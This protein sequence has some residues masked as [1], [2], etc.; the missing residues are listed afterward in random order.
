MI[1]TKPARQVLEV[2]PRPAKDPQ[3]RVGR[4]DERYKRIAPYYDLLDWPFEFFRY[5]RIRR[6]VVADLSGGGNVGTVASWGLDVAHMPEPV[7]VALGIA[8]GVFAF[9]YLGRRILT[10]RRE[11][12]S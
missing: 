8:G 12:R 10:R 9:F 11:P 3:G 2:L 4:I 5:R 6:Q 7:N 1:P